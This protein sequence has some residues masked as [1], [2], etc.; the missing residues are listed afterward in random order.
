MK[1]TYIHQYYLTPEQGGA[2][3]SYHLAKGLADAGWE[4][5]VITGNNQKNYEIGFEG[6]VKVHKLAVSYDN[7]F[8][9]VRRLLSFLVFVHKAKRLIRS[10]EKPDLFIFPLPH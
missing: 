3:R 4:V 6:K 1:I 9:F 2:I 8:G 5:D 10:L 7:Q